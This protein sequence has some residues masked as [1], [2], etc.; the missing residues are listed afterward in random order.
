M[1][2]YTH[3]YDKQ[4]T[5]TEQPAVSR[6]WRTWAGLRGRAHPRPLVKVTDGIGTPNP[7]PRHLQS[8]C[9]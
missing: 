3:L 2:M 7:N 6:S 4:T 5:V 1:Y 9:F 8:W